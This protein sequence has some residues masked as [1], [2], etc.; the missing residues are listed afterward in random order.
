MSVE[1][2]AHAVH[3][4]LP[5][6]CTHAQCTHPLGPQG[7]HKHTR[8]H[9]SC[10]TLPPFMPQF[11]HTLG[12]QGGHKHTRLH[13]SCCTL[14]TFMPQFT[15]PLGPQGGHKHTR[16]HTSCCTL[17]PFMPQCTHLLQ[18]RPVW[19]EGILL[20]KSRTRPLLISIC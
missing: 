5:V 18:T 1:A 7:G 11:T 8:L 3:P 10:C 20:S 19:K 2:S 9:T 17:P 6:T 12:P 13:T 16:L 4:L 14:P 15:H